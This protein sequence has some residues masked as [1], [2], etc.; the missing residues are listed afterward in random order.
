EQSQAQA[1]QE[2]LKSP[3]MDDL[4][5]QGADESAS[6]GRVNMKSAESDE[7]PQRQKMKM[8]SRPQGG[9][10]GKSMNRAQRRR[11]ERGKRS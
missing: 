7:A 5:F 9:D 11:L 6:G 8:V 3:D 4:H 2:M 10:D 1:M